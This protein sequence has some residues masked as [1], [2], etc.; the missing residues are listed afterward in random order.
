MKA[1]I[2][3][4]NV[5]RQRVYFTSLIFFIAAAS[6]FLVLFMGN[7]KSLSSAPVSGDYQAIASGDWNTLGIWQKYNGSAWIAATT[8]PVQADKVITIKSGST[9]TISTA[10]SIDQIVIEAGGILF[11]NSGITLTLRKTTSPDLAVYGIFR[12][13]GTLV[14]SGGSMATYYSGGTYQHNYTTTSGTIPTSV[15]NTGSTCEIY[16]YT[17]NAAMPGGLNQTFDNLKWNCASQTN[18]VNM[19]G[20]FSSFT[21]NFIVQSTGI[22]EL[23][24]ANGNYTLN[25]TGNMT[26]NGGVLNYCNVASKT[27][28]IN[29]T[30]NLYINGGTLNFASG[31][32]CVGNINLTG[33][34]FQT[35]G[36]FNFGGGNS[37]V[38]SMVISGDF[39]QTGGVLTTTGT[40]AGGTVVFSGAVAQSFT[41]SGN[42]VSGSVDYTINNGAT[43]NMGTSAVLGRNFTLNSGGQI[44]IGSPNGITSSGSVGNVQV[45][46]TR[47]FNA[48]G[49]YLYNGTANQITGNGLPALINKLTINNNNYLTLTAVT[50]V[51]SELSM[52]SGKILTGANEVIVTN[53][54]AAAITGNLTGSWVVGNLRRTITS[55]GTFDYP[56]GSLVNYELMSITTSGIVGI[57]SMVGSFVNAVT[58]D[59]TYPLTVAVNGVDL[60]EMLDHGYWTISPFGFRLA[61]TYSVQVNERGYS[62]MLS[63]GTFYSLLSRNNTTSAW[64]SAGTHTDNTQSVSGGTVTALRSGLTTFYQY[65]IALGDLPSLFN[66]SLIS[67]TAGAVGA[68]YLFQDAMRGVD[69]WTTITNLYNGA[70]LSDIDNAAVGYNESFQPFVNFPANKD[71]YIEWEVRFKKA[72]TSIDT[73]LAKI[74][75]TG[76]DVDGGTGIREYIVATM[77]TSYSL[78]PATVLTMSSDSGRYKAIGSTT[79]IANI[80]TAHHE[81]M[82]QLNYNNVNKILYRTGTVN[83]TSSSATR[84][85]SLY[86]RS[87]LIGAPVFALP[88]KL[89]EF[90]ASPKKDRVL[91]NW[92]TATETNNDYFTVERSGDGINFKTLF[93]KRGAGT[94]TTTRFY[95]MADENPL[96]GQSYYRLK[97]TDYDGKFT[98]SKM[99]AVKIGKNPSESDLVINSVS[100]NPFQSD[101]QIS[102]SIKSNGIVQIDLM[103]TEGKVIESKKLNVEEGSGS[104][105]FEK[106]EFLK[107]GTYFIIVEQN[108]QRQ[109]R[110]IIKN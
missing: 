39:S 78:D 35:G 53:T 100:P 59:T 32:I 20:G 24:M 23:Q 51:S 91:L 73:T 68:T 106:T 74:S 31:N 64:Q 110:K 85:T 22:A 5:L 67:G 99:Q 8:V 52:L 47:S 37:V 42:T 89:V 57:A 79:S 28:T 16:G 54:S 11:L 63:N 13:A 97:Q 86:F 60:T 25:I 2:R 41:A 55:T 10:L 61:G 104:Y 98:Y 107:P 90:K 84:Q 56:V 46:G 44:G 15:W 65:G 103:N 87:F 14:Y 82:Y 34:Y 102:Y 66:P 94:T 4:R 76:V 93:T 6:L 38:S 33:N 12:N 92:T 48:G 19:A 77:P 50:M 75:A 30:G 69:M 43:V 96:E 105:N 58:N 101:L 9:V 17:T 3:L 88:I 109:T 108:G 71:S 45:S 70:T 80:D 95:E 18:S 27:I 29:Q 72:N 83:T 21:G 26:I 1:K 81:A 40:N 62:N 36:T 49:N 7:N